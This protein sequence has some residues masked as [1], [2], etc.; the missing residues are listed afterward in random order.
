MW[1]W[2][3]WCVSTMRDRETRPSLLANSNLNFQLFLSRWFWFTP[4][5]T[6][7]FMPVGIWL[8]VSAGCFTDLFETVV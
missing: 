3:R 1:A 4:S 5:M 7:P 6:A 8:G 2:R